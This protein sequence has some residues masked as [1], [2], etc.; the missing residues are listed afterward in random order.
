MEFIKF[1]IFLLL[2]V[3]FTIFY[4]L[5]NSNDINSSMKINKISLD[6]QNNEISDKDIEELINNFKSD[7][8]F[9]SECECKKDEK[10]YVQIEESDVIVF[11]NE[12]EL[13]RINKTDFFNMNFTC[14][15]YHVFRRGLNQKVIGY[16]IFGTN[17]RYSRQVKKIV[18]LA[19]SFY[20]DWNLRIYYDHTINMSIICE[21][22]CLKENESYL[23][24]ADFCN[25]ETLSFKF[26]DY[27]MNK[28]QNFSDLHGRVWRLFILL[29]KIFNFIYFLILFIPF[30]DGFQYMIVLL[31]F[32]QVEI[33]IQLLSNVKLIQLITGLIKLIKLVI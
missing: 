10:I 8:E 13:Y 33:Q 28:T 9:R 23:N 31:I 26:H 14:D 15:L 3:I 2:I 19:K 12:V 29:F 17:P 25:V 5:S 11:L 6:E 4:L 24:N 22:E 30:L 16:T 7:F 18:G 32:F 27:I 1:Y 20:P 21:I